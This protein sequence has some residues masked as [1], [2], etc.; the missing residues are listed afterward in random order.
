M[1]KRRRRGRLVADER[2]R[3]VERQFAQA[4]NDPACPEL[5]LDDLDVQ[6][7]VSAAARDA[8][9]RRRPVGAHVEREAG[10]AVDL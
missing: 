5:V 2:D 7:A 10:P 9:R 3:F 1:H 4:R 6:E 8:D